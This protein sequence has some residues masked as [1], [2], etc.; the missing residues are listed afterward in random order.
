MTE[1][2][3]QVSGKSCESDASSMNCRGI[4]IQHAVLLPLSQL[5]LQNIPAHF[6][7]NLIIQLQYVLEIYL[8]L[9]YLGVDYAAAIATLQP[10]IFLSTHAVSIAVNR[11]TSELVAQFLQAAQMVASNT[12]FTYGITL[13]ILF[14]IICIAIVI[15][16]S[17][18]ISEYF[19]PYIAAEAKQYIT[20]V[21]GVGCAMGL[22]STSM[23]PY[24]R[25]ENRK[26]VEL[27]MDFGY[28][29][30]KLTT[31]LV[32][33]ALYISQGPSTEETPEQPQK[34]IMVAVAE[35]AGQGFALVISLLAIVPALSQASGLKLAARYDLKLFN[36]FRFKVLLN[37]LKSII[38][39]YLYEARWALGTIPVFVSIIFNENGSDFQKFI[40]IFTYYMLRIGKIASSVNFASEPVMLA[41]GA[42]NMSVKR[43]D[44]VFKLVLQSLILVFALSFTF[45]FICFVCAPAFTNVL[46]VMANS[47]LTEKYTVTE[48]E[49]WLSQFSF[50]K[51]GMIEGMGLAPLQVCCNIAIFTSKPYK[52]AIYSLFQLLIN[53]SLSVALVTQEGVNQPLYQGIYLTDVSLLLFQ[54]PIVIAEV[55]G[56]YKL[57]FVTQAKQDGDMGGLQDTFND[58]KEAANIDID[59]QQKDSELINVTRNDLS[60]LNG[61]SIDFYKNSMLEDR[62]G[63]KNELNL[64]NSLLGSKRES[65]PSRNSKGDS[66]EMALKTLD[67]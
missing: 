13:A 66:D 21:G 48:L 63:K 12:I 32:L 59:G 29:V 40:F 37:I 60:G 33:M 47:A 41:I 56:L 19:T 53:S 64:I 8:V 7:M 6:V 42:I 54:I 25:V 46:F 20:L 57:Q 38:P 9:F 65:Q 26:S 23:K 17:G 58:Q 45:A 61:Q 34:F 67:E 50:L 10:L 27:Y 1:Y 39:F 31:L 55:F 11:A 30:I 22:F 2:K 18:T 51:W 44:R 49:N 4:D 36:P 15:S 5:L 28:V 52:L 14:S 35:L 62:D 43:Y 24:Y 3:S 16:L